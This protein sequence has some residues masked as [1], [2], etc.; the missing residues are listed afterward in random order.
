ELK[1]NL[2]PPA[3]AS[4]D[5][6]LPA[7]P[8]KARAWHMAAPREAGPPGAPSPRAID[9][10]I[11]GFWRW[12]TVVVPPNVYVVHTR[13][14]HAEPVPLPP[15]TPAAAPP[16]R[17][18]AAPVTLGLGTSFRFDPTTDAFLLIPASM[19]TLALNAKCITSERQGVLVQAYVQ[20]I[21]EDVAVAYRRL[22]FSDVAEPMRIVNVQLREQAEAVLQDNV[23]T[24]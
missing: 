8:A 9:Y 16:R 5:M 21:V 18:H 11:S 2:L 6:D 4:P 17:G 24:I 10:R 13:R 15:P 22:D 12:K 19:Q 14:G 1:R 7:A 23:A 20:W 3:P